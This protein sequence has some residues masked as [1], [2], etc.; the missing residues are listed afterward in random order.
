MLY[1]SE[2]Q[3]QI[4]LLE[5]EGQ[6]PDISLSQPMELARFTIL[7]ICVHGVAEIN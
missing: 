3:H 5:L 2:A 6:L 1:D 7:R 4:E